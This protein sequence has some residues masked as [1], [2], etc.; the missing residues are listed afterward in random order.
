MRQILSFLLLMF[1]TTNAFSQDVEKV[2]INEPQEVKALI[3]KYISYNHDRN[4]IDGYRIQIFFDSGNNSKS[5]AYAK[6]SNFILKYPHIRAYITYQ[7]PNYKV[8]VGDFR[9]KLDAEKFR[10]EILEEYPSAFSIPEKINMP[11][12]DLYDEI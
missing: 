7:S 3:S 10:Q 6:K 5:R 12:L 1:L 8:R 9:T 2:K 4:G 11:S